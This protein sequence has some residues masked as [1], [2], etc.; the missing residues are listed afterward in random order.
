MDMY[1]MFH[2]EQYNKKYYCR[3][4]FH[5]EHF[6][7]FYSKA[8]ENLYKSG[9]IIIEHYKSILLLNQRGEKMKII[10][11][12]NQKGGVGK[13]TTS[14]NLS[15]CLAEKKQKVLVIDSDP[16]GN[17]TSGLGIDKNKSEVTF[18][19]VLINGNAMDDAVVKT[20]WNN[21]YVCPSNIELSGAEVELVEKDKREFILKAAL[22]NMKEKFDY[23][24]IDCPPSL[25]LL[26][27][28]AFTAADTVLIPIQCEYYALEGLAELTKTIKTVRMGLNPDLDIEGALLTMFD[29]RTNLSVEV[30]E[31]VKK[32][33]P[34]KVFKTI[35]PRNVRLSEAP[36]FGEPVIVHDASSKG[37]ACYRDLAKEII[38]NNKKRR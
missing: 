18:Y 30:V 33:L 27:V 28:N 25:T 3:K 17:T 6:F 36:S 15:A 21:L 5:V 4:M 7:V 20:K 11:I 35:I 34:K 37:A 31:Q 23:V 24:I 9:I 13:T 32:A 8:I 22:E 29:S 38:K 26:T 1:K 16:Q 12:A 10:A 14:V 19:D 2:V